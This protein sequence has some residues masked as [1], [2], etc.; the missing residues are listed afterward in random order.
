MD[1][2]EIVLNIIIHSGNARSYAME[3]I[4]Y[5]KKGEV[6]KAKKALEDSSNEISLAHNIQTNLI[7]NEACGQKTEVTLLMVHA[8]DH[9]MNGLTVKDLA[10]EM[11]DM[12]SKIL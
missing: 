1:Y 11:V 3:A 6:D 5:A 9:L 10:S 4:S 8:Q 7:Q 12:Y 2:N